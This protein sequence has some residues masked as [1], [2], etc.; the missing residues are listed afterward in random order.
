[1][2]FKNSQGKLGIIIII[3]NTS[4]LVPKTKGLFTIKKKKKEREREI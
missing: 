3:I 2:A 1:M 4:E